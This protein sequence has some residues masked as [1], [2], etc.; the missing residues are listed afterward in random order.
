MAK[1]KNSFE[2]EMW[3]SLKPK[4]TLEK[5]IFV[6]ALILITFILV[7][8]AFS[9]VEEWSVSKKEIPQHKAEELCYSIGFKLNTTTYPSSAICEN[10]AYFVKLC[11]KCVVKKKHYIYDELFLPEKS[12]TE[13]K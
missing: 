11:E 6:I 1:T 12:F 9:I 10:E 13:V 7:N 5:M 2:K 8:L 3:E 4:T